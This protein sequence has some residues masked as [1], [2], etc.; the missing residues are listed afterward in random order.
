MNRVLAG[1][2]VVAALAGCSPGEPGSVVVTSPVSP[3]TAASSSPPSA[4]TDEPG[5]SSSSPSIGDTPLEEAPPGS[6]F[7]L[8]AQAGCFQLG[9]AAKKDFFI[10]AI[11]K[12]IVQVDCSEPHHFEVFA[13]KD[14]DGFDGE[15]NLTQ[16]DAGA[17]CRVAY[18]A[19]FGQDAPD[20]ITS[21][22]Q[23]L[24]SPYLY[25]F[26]PDD[27]LEATTYPGRLICGVFTADPEYTLMLSRTGSL[28]A[29]SS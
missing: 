14:V 7:Y 8:E 1:L 13:S 12:S 18:Q 20:Q 2:L 28:V 17:Y 3:L 23:Q 10:D 21:P 24:R 4:D 6:V 25:W 27:G 5:T 22:K 15:T 29:Q 19:V 11:G 9:K 26:F 16:E